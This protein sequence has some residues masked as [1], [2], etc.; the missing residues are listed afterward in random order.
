MLTI[1]SIGLA[2]R[3]GEKL[4]K[5]ELAFA[6]GVHA[7]TLEDEVDALSNVLG[8]RYLRFFMKALEELVLLLGDVDRRRDLAAGH[9]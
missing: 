7:V 6:V 3:L 1:A 4:F 8:D 9:G 5:G 2:A